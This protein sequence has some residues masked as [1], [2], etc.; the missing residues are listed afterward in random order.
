MLISLLRAPAD[1]TNYMI[2]GFAF[3]Y[4]PTFLY[5][6]SLISRRKKL[7]KEI[8]ILEEFEN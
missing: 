2:L 4:G 7:E 6:W 8:E 5:V 3:I 1:T